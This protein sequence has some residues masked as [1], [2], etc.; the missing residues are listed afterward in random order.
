[1]PN[2]PNNRLPQLDI[3]RAVAVF[4]VVG[5]HMT[6]CAPETNFYVNKITAFW[7]RGGWVGV[8][9]FFV[10]SGF[11]VSGLLFREYRKKENLNIKRFLIRRGF[12]IYP[13]FW[14]LIAL[15]CFAGL[16][17]NVNFYRLG[18]FG[19]LAFIQN[20]AGNLWEHTWTL[21]VEE[22]FYIGLCLLFYLLLKDKKS[23]SENAFAGIPRIFI[24]IA[25]GC[26]IM[27]LLTEF[28]LPFQYERNIEP[29]HLRVDS[30]FFG[31]LI[32][33]FWHFR[34]LSDNKFLNRNKLLLGIS[35][36]MLL[37]PA[38]V[39]ELEENHWIGVIGL[40][41]FYLG[42]GFLLLF[43]LKTDFSKIPF[44][45]SVAYIGTFSY[46]IY[47]WN[48]PV[49]K[50][51]TK[52]AANLTGIENWYFYFAV[53]ILGTFLIGIGM[54]KIIEY[55]FLKIRNRYFP[56]LSPPLVQTAEK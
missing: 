1:M 11:L 33:Y 47:L 8:D 35:G 32:S 54:S 55:P 19:E 29:T 14:V 5:N 25:V 23:A 4:L 36:V 34:N 13:A 26:F 39:F 51:L 38:F 22:H 41:M 17:V 56:T 6:I 3:L 7:L 9:L 15:T 42:S 16:F 2:A 44:A 24:I 28:Y 53:Y 48:M 27:R 30:L 45:K 21:A 37:L 52:A 50:W 49:Q 18:L 40:P 20:Y 10:L 31:V 46:S 43:F 12:K